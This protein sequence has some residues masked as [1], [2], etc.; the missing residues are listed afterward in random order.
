M[1]SASRHRDGRAMHAP[2]SGRT[3]SIALA[4]FVSLLLLLALALAACTAGTPPPGQQG[5]GTTGG[6]ARTLGPPAPGMLDEL[7]WHRV[8]FVRQDGIYTAHADGTQLRKLVEL[9]GAFEY[10]PDVSP[11]GRWLALRVDDGPSPG[12]WLVASDGTGAHNLTKGAGLARAGSPDWAPDSR[13]LAVVGQRQG[14]RRFGIYV[15]SID[16]PDAKRITP[17]AWEAQYP[18]WSPDGTQIAFTRVEPSANSFDLYVTAPDGSQRRQLTRH[19]AEDNYAAWSPDGARLVFSSERGVAGLGLWTIGADGADER[20]LTAGGEPQWEPA[21]VI[22]YDCPNLEPSA[23]SGGPG[24]SCVVRPDGS[25]AARL[26]LGDEAVF[27]NWT[28][29]GR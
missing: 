7:R 17:L 13:R 18:A 22:V 9:K 14:E 8:V 16:G 1:R 25:G 2:R 28:P 4:G 23:E 6:A 29:S 5:G 20:F 12:T 3:P 19:P 21:S 15:V 11:D 26:Q 27:P 24:H 10:Q